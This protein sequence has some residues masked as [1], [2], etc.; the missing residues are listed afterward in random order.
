MNADA[1]SH[2]CGLSL[3]LCSVLLVSAAQLAL[4]YGMLNWPAPHA[5]AQMLAALPQ[6]SW[7]HVLLPIGAGIGC[8]G[9]SVL[10]WIAALG[11]LPL[12]LAYP[13]LSL[14]YPLVYIGAA[15]LPVF[16]EAIN[17]RRLAGIALIMVGI[18]LLV[19]RSR[20]EPPREIC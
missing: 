8:Y 4:K 13:L 20:T 5:P 7:L 17:G 14:S 3:A 9:L 12:S 16:H 2:R 1:A 6:L 19:W 18:V 10:C 15:L 11:R